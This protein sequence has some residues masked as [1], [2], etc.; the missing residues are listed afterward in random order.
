MFAHCYDAAIRRRFA[1]ACIAPSGDNWTSRCHTVVVGIVACGLLSALGGARAGTIVVNDPDDFDGTCGVQCT[2][3]QAINTANFAVGPDT[4]IFNISGAGLHTIALAKALPAIT[5][6]V[7]IDGHTQPGTISNSSAVGTNAVLTIEINGASAPAFTPGLILGAGSA[8]STI[9]ELVI[10]GFPYHGI[11]FRDSS[12]VGGSV[13]GCFIGIDATGVVAK[14]NMGDGIILPPSYSGVTIGGPA[15]A[16]RNLIS[17]NNHGVELDSSNNS[18]QGNLI[19]TRADGVSLIG[20]GDGIVSSASGNLIGGTSVGTGNVIAGNRLAG[21]L[22]GPLATGVEI[23]RN[24]ISANGGLGIDLGDDGVTANDAGDVD[25]GSNDFQN[26]PVLTSATVDGGVLTATGS[27]NSTPSRN[28]RIEIFANMSADPSGHG[29]GQVFVSSTNIGTDANGDAQ[30]LMHGSVTSRQFITALATDTVTNS[31][32][33]FSAAIQVVSNTTVTNT[34]D[35]GPGSLRQAITNANANPGPDVID[36]AIPG[37]G[38]H[39]ISPITAL[40]TI[41]DTVTI[42]GYTQAGATPNTLN[43]SDDAILL[44]QVDGSKLNFPAGG[45]AACAANTV[46]RGLAVTG[47]PGI[48]ISFGLNNSG[49]TCLV[50]SANGSELAGSFIGMGP[51]GNSIGNADG[52]WVSGSSVQIG[53]SSPADRNVVSA[54]DQAGVEFVTPGTAGSLVAGNLIGWAPNGTTPAGNNLGGVV[55]AGSATGITIGQDGSPTGNRIG[56]NATGI[57]VFDGAKARLFANDIGPNLG[58]GIDLI[59]PNANGPDGVTPNDIDDVDTGGNNLQN[60][61]D[62]IVVS[63]KAFTGLSISGHLDRP[64]TAGPLTYV[65]AVYASASCNVSGHGEGE[66]Y[67]QGFNFLTTGPTD[68]TFTNIPFPTSEPL[69]V[70]T[71]I[72]LTATDP[73]GNTSE[74]SQCFPLDGVSQTFVVNSTADSDDGNCTADP[75][76][77]TLREAINAANV[78]SGIGDKIAFGIPGNGVHVISPASALPTIT[79]PV[80]IDGYTQGDASANTLFEGDNAKI[81][82][83]V[84]GTATPSNTTGFAI[85]ANNTAVSGLSITGFPQRAIHTHFD[86]SGQSCGVGSFSGIQVSGNFIGLAPDGSAAYNH[87]SGILVNDTAARIG[88]ILPSE[89][90]IVSAN[91]TL[92]PLGVGAIDVIGSVSGTAIL[93]NYI[94]TDPSGTLDRGNFRVGVRI[95]A[96][97]SAVAVGG[98]APN[99]IAFNEDGILVDAT[100]N[101][102]ALFANDM[103]SNVGPQNR[104]LAIDLL[105]GGSIPDGLTANDPDDG[106]SGGND[107]QNFP[108]LTSAMQDGPNVRLVGTLDVPAGTTSNIYALAFYANTTCSGPSG[109][110]Q[111]EVYLGYA[112]VN[113]SGASQEFVIDLPANAPL[114]SL[115]AATATSASGTSEFS[116]CVTLTAGDH[117]FANGFQL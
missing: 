88:G 46:V 67:L 25:V 99:R 70:G 109:R 11:Q 22:V 15:L 108:A 63:R 80:A 49:S 110:G 13:K 43:D 28:F 71:Q 37:S 100:S 73:N 82:I 93:G 64:A 84:D 1:F 51:N 81:L 89:R 5:S 6:P 65:I 62:N 14:P 3:R 78:H 40:P 115:I 35:S 39:T 7:T 30:I 57:V 10:N 95:A 103:F 45:L 92:S 31:T 54:N 48:A 91:N 2:L 34:N 44:I 59:Q 112:N 38:V 111:G 33:E 41:T 116:T 76:G 50:G 21:V 9:R 87:D 90:N 79:D 102:N 58:L 98:A 55:V 117:I 68:E 12:N 94:G 105:A 16:D 18:V 8:P 74:F 86:S 47:V 83:Q 53:G 72:T 52:V 114:G 66:R 97:S 17:G 29:E 85:C 61:P 69:P 106:D 36:F 27:L 77:C 19:G 101:A 42:D 4:I 96:S 24:S 20:N 23:V 56:N 75:G 60:F 32:S 107:L 26:F 104:G 113:L